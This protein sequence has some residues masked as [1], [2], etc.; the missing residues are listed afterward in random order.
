VKKKTFLQLFLFLII[1][2]IIM[3]F[4]NIYLKDN[5]SLK[6]TN[7]KKDQIENEEPTDTDIIYNLEYIS[8]DKNGNEYVI[9]SEIGE[10]DNNQLDLVLMKNVT[11]QIKLKNASPIYISSIKAVYNKNN[12]NTEFFGDVSASYN[13]HFFTSGN[14]SLDFDENLVTIFNNVIYQNLNTNLQADRIE[15]DL[16][17]KNSI[18]QMNDKSE[19]VKIITVN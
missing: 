4:Y 6:N 11:A 5:S 9:G 16:I 3:L 13:D 7:L 8:E 10:I 17:T 18:I 1:I 15:I 19:K 14:L 2:T 12:Y